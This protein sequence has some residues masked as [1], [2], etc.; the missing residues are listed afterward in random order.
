[1][2]MYKVARNF[3]FWLALIAMLLSQFTQLQREAYGVQTRLFFQFAEKKKVGNL[4][5]HDDGTLVNVN[6][7]NKDIEERDATK[8]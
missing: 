7:I 8:R 4:N 3:H 6:D 5:E 2:F 1:M